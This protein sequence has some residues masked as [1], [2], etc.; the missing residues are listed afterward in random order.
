MAS[1]FKQAN[2]E[3]DEA[4]G[5]NL[6]MRR[7]LLGITQDD[8]AKQIGVSFQQIQKYERGTNR[9][10]ASALWRITGVLQCTV[11]DMFQDIEAPPSGGAEHGA[12]TAESR[13]ER[14]VQDLLRTA[15]GMELA[16]MFIELSEDYQRALLGSAKAFMRAQAPA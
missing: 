12:A 7:H 8:L 5:K 15:G 13:P 3:V 9:M 2:R 14:L 16:Q 11:A 4:V 6:R 1:T 10:S